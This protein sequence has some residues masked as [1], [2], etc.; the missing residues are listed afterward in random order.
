[1]TSYSPID[2]ERASQADLLDKNVPQILSIDVDAVLKK[3]YTPFLKWPNWFQR[4]V[5]WLLRLIIRQDR[6]NKFLSE[7]SHLQSFEFIEKAFD[8]LGFR[9]HFNARDI[10][11]IPARGGVIIFANHPLGALDGLS[12][13]HLVSLV[14][15]DVKIVANQLL[16]NITPLA[17]LL[18]PVD[19]MKGDSRKQDLAN[20]TRALEAD[21]VVIFFPAGEVSRL[22]PSG[23]QDKV[24]DAG[25]LRF[26][27]RL[28][29][30]VMPIYI[31]ACNSGLFYAIA[32]LSAMASML[33]LPSEMTRYSGRFQFFTSPVIAPDQFA[34]L[35]LSRR[36]KVKLLRKHLYQLPKNKRPVFTTKESLIHPRNRQSLRVELAL[37]EELGSTS[38]GKRILLFTPHTD[39]AVLDELGRLREE[40]FRAVGEGT[41]RKK[42]TDRFDAYYRHIIVWDDKLL[43]IAGAYRLGEVWKWCKQ[44][45][46]YHKASQGHSPSLPQKL[47]SASLFQFDSA[48]ASAPDIAL[49]SGINDNI[50]AVMEA[51]LELGRSFVQPRFWGKRSLDYLWQGIG[52]Y[53]ARHPEVRYLFGPVSLSASLPP[54]A[55]DML[56][57]YYQNYYPES[58]LLA[59]PKAGFKL[60]A[61]AIVEIEKLMDGG[62]PEGDF[63]NLREQLSHMQVRIP[64]LYRQYSELC[65]YGGVSF[66]AFNVDAEFSMCLDSFVMVDLEM[67]K[68]AKYARYVAPYLSKEAAL[69]STQPAQ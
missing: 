28:N 19:N 17:P 29:L 21:Q 59:V 68:P 65:H 20:I 57:W 40:A 44:E 38:D 3:H 47:Y 8:E 6:I 18:L 34:T 31:R 55:R 67:V 15:R 69:T 64:T 66:S 43:E 46:G 26:A 58:Q 53:I 24:W 23:I 51:G 62:D 10:E 33:L 5:S 25:F 39:S 52:A 54:R 13:L 1:M 11:N 27:E 50:G 49:D 32:R 60:S 2:D 30:P 9:Y 12:L 4:L 63:I 35:P 45:A 42:D 7:N 56:V 16:S 36:Q 41:G 48:P 14:R 22:S 61:S 37:A